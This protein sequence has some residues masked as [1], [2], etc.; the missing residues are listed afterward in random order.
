MDT[1]IED[2][3]AYQQGWLDAQAG[4]EHKEPKPL[5]YTR[6]YQKY[7]ETERVMKETGNR[8]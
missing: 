4:I 5:D 1:D 7:N 3:D 8:K 2:L 6:A